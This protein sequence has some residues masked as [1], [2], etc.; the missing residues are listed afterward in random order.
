MKWLL[1]KIIPILFVFF[2]IIGTANAKTTDNMNIESLTK[3]ISSI[4]SPISNFSKV[5]DNYY[6]GAQPNLQS[7]EYLKKLGI[8]TIINLRNENQ[9]VDS[10]EKISVLKNGINYVNIPMRPDKPPTQAQINQFFNLTNNSANLPVYVHCLQGK[11]RTGIMTALYR[12]NEYNWSFKKT[13]SEMRKMGYHIYFYPR[14][15]WFLANY[16]KT[17][18]RTSN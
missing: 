11:D 2:A 16:I 8:K 15:K 5:D 6:R 18:S 1:K 12:F 13:Y 3:K 17:H 10:K 4:N 7:I 14:Q 9:I